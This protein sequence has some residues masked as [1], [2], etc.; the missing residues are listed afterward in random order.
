MFLLHLD[1]LTFTMD[2]KTLRINGPVVGVVPRLVTED[3][4]LSGTFIPKGSSITIDIF[5]I[6]HSDK[7]WKNADV[8]NPDRFATKDE[9]GEDLA[10]W[11]PFGNGARYVF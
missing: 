9:G 3:T 8:F 1:K 2:T 6:Q 11:I 7:V 5:N 4:V 10:G